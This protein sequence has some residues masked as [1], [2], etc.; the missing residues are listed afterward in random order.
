M[1]SYAY[2]KQARQVMRIAQNLV[3]EKGLRVLGTEYILLG[4]IREKN[5]V[6]GQVLRRQSVQEATVTRVIDE[7]I[8]PFPATDGAE[9]ISL[10]PES[11]QVLERA[12]ELARQYESESV[13]TEHMLL[14]LLEHP[15]CAAAQ[16]LA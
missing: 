13:G 5:G 15:D 2:T 7:M 8:L 14:S 10:M 11:E 1:E 9:A 16:I 6:A 4:M 3:K 12:A